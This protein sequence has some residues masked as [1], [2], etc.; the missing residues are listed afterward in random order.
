MGYWQGLLAGVINDSWTVINDSW[1]VINDSWTVIND[2]WLL[3][4]CFLLYTYISSSF[5]R[6]CRIFPCLI[7]D[8]LRLKWGANLSKFFFLADIDGC[9]GPGYEITFSTSMGG[10]PN[11]V[12][13]KFGELVLKGTTL[14]RDM[15]EP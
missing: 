8:S 15:P 14:K 5:E 11:A 3:C 4:S 1:T 12:V 13:N 7:S 10:A 9:A 6:V 2:S